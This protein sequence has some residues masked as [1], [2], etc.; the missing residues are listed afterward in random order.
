MDWIDTLDSCPPGRRLP[1]EGRSPFQQDADRIVFSSAFRRLQN[2]TQVHP[3]PHTDFVR[4]RLTHSMEVASVGRSLGNQVARRLLKNDPAL[5]VMRPHLAADLG[6]IVAAACLAHDIG[7]PPFGHTGEQAIQHWFDENREIAFKDAL[8]EAE[9]ADLLRFEGNA[10]GYRILTRLQMD[11]DDGGMR[12]MDATLGAFTKYPSCSLAQ[13]SGDYI[14]RKKHGFDAAEAEIFAA[15]AGRLKLKPLPGVQQAWQRH[16]LAYLV[17]AADDICYRVI[18]VE[19]GV[20]LG[21]IG[22]SE[23]E[24]LLQQLI[25]GKQ[26]ENYF[27]RSVDEKLSTLRSRAIGGLLDACCDAFIDPAN[28]FLDGAAG[29][30]LLGATPL[31]GPAKALKDLALQ[32]VYQWERT[33]GEE[34]KGIN[35]IQH[36][37]RLFVAALNAGKKN[38]TAQRLLVLIPHMPKEDAPRYLRLLAI[39]DYI[40]GMTDR[41]AVETWERLR[42][43]AV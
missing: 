25:A 36:M 17:E 4:T 9:Q 28:G 30:D 18:D 14:G 26:S 33:V 27:R 31:Q 37:L 42:D 7:N 1:P 5:A 19:D 34:F 15:M 13:K 22:F 29:K 43:V 10:Q 16:P 8:N 40:S 12:L 11:R 6:D 20:K 24:G 2:K 23:A 21:R 41:F 39:T 35:A 32:R 3:L 38:V